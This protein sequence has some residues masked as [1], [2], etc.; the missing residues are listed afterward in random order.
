MLSD[1]SHRP[2]SC[3]QLGARWCVFCLFMCFLLLS[4]FFHWRKMK[5]QEEEEKKN[6]LRWGCSCRP[7]RNHLVGLPSGEC[8]GLNCSANLYA[9]GHQVAATLL[10][11]GRSAPSHIGG[12]RRER[13]HLFYSQSI[14]AGFFLKFVPFFPISLCHQR[15]SLQEL[16]PQFFEL[17]LN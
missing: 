3:C 5:G 6:D 15:Y 10:H 16:K 13:S 17:V 7:D 2:A 8:H 12:H 1:H 9:Q 14:L 11:S 4:S